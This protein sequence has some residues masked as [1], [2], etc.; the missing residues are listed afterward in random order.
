MS[1]TTAPPSS[2]PVRRASLPRIFGFDSYLVMLVGVMIVFGLVMV[3]SASWDV[4]WRL[5]GDPNALFFR[6]LG[7]LLIGLLAM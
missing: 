2:R 5:Q 4:S 7:N 6:Q 1:E 3:Y